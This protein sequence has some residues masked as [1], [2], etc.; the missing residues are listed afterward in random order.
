MIKLYG[1]PLSHYN[2][3]VKVF[4]LEKGFDFEEIYIALAEA[5]LDKR[6]ND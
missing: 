1:A 5:R 6:A 2:A 3:M 4:L